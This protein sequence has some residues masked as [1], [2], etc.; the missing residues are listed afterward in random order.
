MFIRAKAVDSNALIRYIF[1]WDTNELN[2]RYAYSSSSFAE[3][4][5]AAVLR[6]RVFHETIGIIEK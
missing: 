6:G 4:I 1:R 3:K 2:L 5:K